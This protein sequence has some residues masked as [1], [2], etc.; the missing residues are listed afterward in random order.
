MDGWFHDFSWKIPSRSGWWL[1]IP[2]IWGTPHIGEYV[3]F[4][5]ILLFPPRCFMYGTFTY[6]WLIY[7]INIGKYSST[8]EH[9]GHRSSVMDSE[10]PWSLRPMRL[11]ITWLRQSGGPK[12]WSLQIPFSQMRSKALPSGYDC[13]IAGLKMAIE[14]V[15]FTHETAD[16]P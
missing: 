16:F 1:G 3:W 11:A 14:I 15:F 8:M 6:I 5:V 12:P 2:L 9:M 10:L 13:H 7:G 4:Q